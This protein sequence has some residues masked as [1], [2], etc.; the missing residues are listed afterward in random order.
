[1]VLFPNP[2]ATQSL[3]NFSSTIDANYTIA[4][5]D[6]SGRVLRTNEGSAVTG[7]NTAQISVDGLSKGVYIVALSLNGETRQVKLNVQ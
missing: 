3:L 5:S 1:M 2:T 4:I 7:E 6:L